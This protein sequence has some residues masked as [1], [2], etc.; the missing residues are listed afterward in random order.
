MQDPDPTRQQQ[1]IKQDEDKHQQDRRGRERHHLGLAKRLGKS[2]EAR[3]GKQKRRQEQNTKQI[4]RTSANGAAK[5]REAKHRRAERWTG[6]DW[7]GRTETGAHERP[8]GVRLTTLYTGR[9][10]P[11][12]GKLTSLYTKRAYADPR[13]SI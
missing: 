9:G 6:P 1:D 3:V 5:K 12:G 8:N 11:N 4:K 7:T 13:N 10:Y 2:G